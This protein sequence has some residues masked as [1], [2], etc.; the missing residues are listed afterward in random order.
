MDQKEECKIC[1]DGNVKEVMIDIKNKISMC[2]KTK[3]KG[4]EKDSCFQ[5][6]YM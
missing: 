2:I 1:E 5:N 6:L 3:P 4:R